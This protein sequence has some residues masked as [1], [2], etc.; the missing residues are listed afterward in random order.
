ML[1]L[2][3][4][5]KGDCG[6]SPWKENHFLQR[7]HD[8]ALCWDGGDCPQHHG[9][10]LICGQLQALA[11]FFKYHEPQTLCPSDGGRLDKGLRS[12]HDIDSLHF[13]AA[14]L[15]P[16]NHWSLHVWLVPTVGACLHWHSHL[17]PF[18]SHQQWIYLHPNLLL[19]AC[20]LWGHPAV[21]ENP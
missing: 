19:V 6:L 1:L 21:S 9:L 10:W 15:W 7:L 8:P 3:H 17:W 13:P 4:C 20:L 18:G 12:F 14:F 2:C 11:L 5:P 16:P